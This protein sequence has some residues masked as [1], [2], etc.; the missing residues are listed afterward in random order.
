METSQFGGRCS[1]EVFLFG[2]VRNACWIRDLSLDNASGILNQI[3]SD[4]H[5]V[6]TFSVDRN[7]RILDA[8]RNRMKFSAVVKVPLREKAKEEVTVQ[9]H[10]S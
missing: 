4:G 5:A 7:R 1:T 2:R 9:V 6:R 3:R 10:M 8:S